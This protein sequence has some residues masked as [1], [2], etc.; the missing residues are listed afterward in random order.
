MSKDDDVGITRL[1]R[2]TSRYWLARV[3]IN[4]HRKTK[5]F[6]ESTYG[7]T[8]QAKEAARQWVAHVKPTH[9]E[10]AMDGRNTSGVKGVYRGLRG[11]RPYWIASFYVQKRKCKEWLF[12]IARLGEAE[13]FRQAVAKRQAMEALYTTKNEPHLRDHEDRL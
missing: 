7:G 6:F 3:M 9:R 4:G 13:A 10:R 8:A 5:A 12:S 1:E 2:G 11:G